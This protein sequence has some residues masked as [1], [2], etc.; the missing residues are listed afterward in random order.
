MCDSLSG[1]GVQ[2]VRHGQVEICFGKS[3]GKDG[4][5][6]AVEMVQMLSF[7]RYSQRLFLTW[8][9]GLHVLEESEQAETWKRHRNYRTFDRVSVS[10][11]PGRSMSDDRWQTCIDE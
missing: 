1:F 7:Y 3:R 6:V 11:Q 8:T 4:R 5:S 9:D 10:R 2:W